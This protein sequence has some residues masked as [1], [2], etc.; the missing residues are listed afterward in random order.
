LCD[1]GVQPQCGNAFDSPCGPA[2]IAV[3]CAASPIRPCSC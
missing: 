2:L 1:M 3:C